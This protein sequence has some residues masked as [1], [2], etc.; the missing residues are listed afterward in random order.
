MTA[1]AP[2]KLTYNGESIS[3]CDE[4]LNQYFELTERDAPFRSSFTAN[5]RGY[6]GEWEIVDN[7]LFLVGLYGSVDDWQSVV[8]LSFIFPDQP[9]RVFGY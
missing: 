8:D 4:P 1:Q 6:V 2:E 5:W 3:L 9:E 7:R